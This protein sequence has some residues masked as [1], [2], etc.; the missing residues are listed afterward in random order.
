MNCLTGRASRL[1]R[2]SSAAGPYPSGEK[3]ACLS[4]NHSWIPPSPALLA[5]LPPSFPPSPPFSVY[6][7]KFIPGLVH[8]DLLIILPS[9][10]PLKFRP[11][12]PCQPS[13][14]TCSEQPLSL[15]CGQLLIPQAISTTAP[16][17]SSPCTY[18]S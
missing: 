15:P 14:V 9:T 11:L 6:H 8:L 10:F 2:G 17:V 18:R 4:L 3:A 12:L 1:H 13:N 5:P 16:C 7:I